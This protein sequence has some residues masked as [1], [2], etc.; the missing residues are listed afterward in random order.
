M[1]HTMPQPGSLE[2]SGR[3]LASLGGPGG[4]GEGARL[5]F[6]R[7]EALVTQLRAHKE[8]EAHFSSLQGVQKDAKTA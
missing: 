6:E 5:I 2:A 7:F 1:H 8:L 4:G 3:P